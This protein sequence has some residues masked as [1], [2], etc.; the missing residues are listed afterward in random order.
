MTLRPRKPTL[1]CMEQLEDRTTPANLQITGLQLLDGFGTVVAAPIIGGRYSVQASWLT[2]DLTGSNN[3]TV[4]ITANGIPLDSSTITGTPGTNVAVSTSQFGWYAASGIN[5]VVAVLD[6]GNAIAETSEADNSLSLNFT[7][8]T[9]TNLPATKFIWPVAGVE[10]KDWSV[11]N[12]TDIDPR[13]GSRSDFR[14]GNFQYDGHDAFDISVPNFRTMDDGLPILAAADG[15]VVSLLDDQFDRDTGAPP[16][17]PGNNIVIDHGNGWS[18][19]YYH[20]VRFSTP[21]KI[22]DTVKAGQVIALVGSS[23][24]SSDAHLHLSVYYRGVQVET[25]YAP[26]IYFAEPPT[27]QGDQV[28][29]ITQAAITNSNPSADIKELPDE[30]TT[31]PTSA[32]QS[33]WLWYRIT[34]YISG[35]LYH[36]KW[37]RPDGSLATT[38]NSTASTTAPYW[39]N[40]WVVSPGTV[41]GSPG[42][43]NVAVERNGTELV[44]KS[45][46]VTTGTGVPELRVEQASTYIIT[47]RTTP[48]D[49]GSVA[50]GGTAPQLAFTIRNP[51][52]ATLTL[53]NLQLPPGYTLVGAFPTSV[54]AGGNATFMVRLDASAPGTKFGAIRLNSNDADEGSFWFNVTGIVTGSPP[55][56]TPVLVD[57]TAFATQ[58]RVGFSPV[59][60]TPGSTLTD[61][62]S[63]NFNTGSATIA[64]ASPAAAGDVLA[65]RN[66]GTTAGLI[67]VSGS[68]VTHGGVNIGSFTG[69]SG[70]SLTVNLNINATLAAVQDLLQNIT[71]QTTSPSSAPRY[72][73]IQVTDNTGLASAAAYQ[74][75]LPVTTADVLSIAAVSPNPTPNAVSSIDVTFAGPIEATTFTFA[76]VSLTRNGGANLITAATTITPVGGNVYRIGNLAGLTGIAGTYVLSVN[77]LLIR[78]TAGVP[79]TTSVSTTWQNV[80]LRPSASIARGPSQPAATNASTIRFAVDFSEPVSGFTASDVQFSGGTLTTGLTAVVI[81]NGGAGASYF[82]DVSGMSSTGTVGI[83]LPDSAVFS[84]SGGLSLAATTPVGEL[85]SFGNGVPVPSFNP[86]VIAATNA[87]SVN[88]GLSFTQAVTGLDIGEIQ[89][90][91]ATVQNLVDLGGGQFTLTVLPTADGAFSVTIPAGVAADT[92]GNLNTTA[93]LT[94]S[95]DRTA[96]VATIELISVPTIAEPPAVFRVSF[97]EAI[98]TGSLTPAD[99]SFAGS[100]VGGA[101]SATLLPDIGNAYFIHVTGM[102]GTGT[103][104]VSLDA[105][106]FTDVAGNASTTTAVADADVLFAPTSASIT[107]TA[108]LPTASATIP[109]T[110]TFSSTVTGFDAS[111][112]AINNGTLSNFTPAGDGRTFTFNLTRSQ[113]DTF[114]VSIAAGAAIDAAGNGTLAA[115]LSGSFDTTAPTVLLSPSVVFPTANSTVTYAATFSETVTGFTAAGLSITN[116][117]IT[118]FLPVGNGVSFL[119]SVNRVTDGPFTLSVNAGAAQDVVG[120]SNAVQSVTG[121]FDTTGPVPTIAPTALQFNGGTATFTVNFNEP[122]ANPAA[123]LASSVTIGG[124]AMPSTVSVAP[125]ANPQSY[126]VTLSGMSANGTVTTQVNSGVVQD[127]LGNG[128]FTSNL[129]SANYVLSISPPT[130]PAV[131]TGYSQFVVGTDRGSAPSIRFLNP[132]G[133]DRATPTPFDASVTGGVRTAAADFNLDGVADIVVGTGP[134]VPSRV[135]VFDGVSRQLLFQTEPFEA[136]FLGGIYV[137]AGDLNGDGRAELVITPD[138]GGGPRITV[139]RG[140]DFARIANFFGIDD[141]NFRGGAR[142]AVGDLTGDGFGDLVVSAGFGGGPRISTYD[143]KALTQNGALVHPVADFFLFEEALRNG[144]FVAVGDVNGDGFADI[145]GGGGPGGGP[146]VYVLSGQELQAGQQVVLANFF[147]GNTENRGGIRVTAKNLDGDQFADIV[148]GDGTG[149]GSHVTAYRGVDFQGSG[150]PS[151]FDFDAF[152]GFEGGIF[153]G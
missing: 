51:G 9:P 72:L 86:T 147:A 149:G 75:L 111:D 20:L 46:T 44:R 48:I 120:N 47:G 60:I 79:G 99:I 102:T 33:V 137:A 118:N 45:F 146:R 69:G 41:N 16:G 18:T 37:Y 5:T 52:T 3:Y 122:L 73:A 28:P 128:S 50:S 15:T 135:R 84:A 57:S 133:T 76:D 11:V 27:Y 93:T 114:L 108:T 19:V 95:V 43:W 124:T 12:Y 140:G 123:F 42:V 85:V 91:N 70:T 71:F 56:G 127:L 34:H 54:V 121:A 82:V 13:A 24:N 49:F 68:T 66:Q 136:A 129:A 64:F 78:T 90:V 23:G 65:I 10:N 117:T 119:F 8:V 144:A 21:V 148:V 101:L 80:P 115:S 26:S 81:P 58:F 107:T 104:R 67:G 143:G 14:G 35:D 89:T 109:I 150:A 1:L 59:P 96:P 151:T 141:A 139:Y 145:I 125:G 32:G 38:Y 30:V 98:A 55:T 31:F 112:L 40:T 152:A 63:A 126:V 116:G 17:H 153:V 132:D 36:I 134:G 138:E 142:A 94:G 105:G 100:T 62:N 4:R 77:S 106:S 25:M 29:A 7:P 88:V 131:L 53:S 61:S 74:T 110:V 83:A 130:N 103:I 87:A 97:S 113:D 92:F 2:T 6:S 22:G 39:W